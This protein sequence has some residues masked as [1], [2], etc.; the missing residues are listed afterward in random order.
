MLSVGTWRQLA[1]GEGS[2]KS[3]ISICKGLERRCMT[4]SIQVSRSVKHHPPS[5]GF[6]QLQRQDIGVG[7][8]GCDL[9]SHTQ[10]SIFVDFG[11]TAKLLT[12]PWLLSKGPYVYPCNDTVGLEAGNSSETEGIRLELLLSF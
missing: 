4:N 1:V 3:I 12:W 5:S 7:R 8:Q 11:Q 2:F 9:L 10:A 6:L